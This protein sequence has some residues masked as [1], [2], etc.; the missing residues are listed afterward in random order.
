M[1][2]GRKSVRVFL[3][4]VSCQLLQV[5]VPAAGQVT[6]PEPGVLP[7][8]S[9]AF[10]VGRVTVLWTDQSRIEPLAPNHEPRELMV[11]IWYPADSAGR[12]TAEYLD[13]AAFEKALGVAGLQKQ[14]GGAYDAIKAGAVR[15]HAVVD[16]PF[17]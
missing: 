15:T 7:P 14:L 11:D 10:G 8:P 5:S 3:M 4:A 17:A 9:G 2:T 16:A 13:A 6:S 12:T 1:T